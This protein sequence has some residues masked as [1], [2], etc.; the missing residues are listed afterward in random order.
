MDVVNHL[1]LAVVGLSTVAAGL[2]LGK[3]ELYRDGDWANAQWYGQDFVT[4]FL[5][6]PV[7]GAVAVASES[8]DWPQGDIVLA[9]LLTYFI[10]TYTF[11][12]FV[13]K[14]NRCYL[15]HVAIL[16]LSVLALILQLN[17]L[18]EAELDI[19]RKPASE[20]HA[21]SPHATIVVSGVYL[22]VISGMLCLL[23]LTDVAGHYMSAE[24]RSDTPTGEPPTLIYTLDLGFVL[25]LCFYGAI[26]VMRD[27]FEGYVIAGMM[28]VKQSTLG[29]ALM[30]MVLSMYRY[31]FA[32]P[33]SLAAL[34]FVLGVTGTIL[35]V[36]Y[37][38]SIDIVAN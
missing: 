16:S 35:S 8:G 27:E 37:F 6:V 24:Y 31:K 4:L 18:R 28:L 9:G 22:M 1:S 2:G 38:S 12:A 3:D 13:A 10:Y 21:G 5:V 34:W 20:S 14:F 26:Q 32:T 23:W 7:T 33:L 30:A 29:F 17:A 25:P 11:Y 36:L 19:S 15:L